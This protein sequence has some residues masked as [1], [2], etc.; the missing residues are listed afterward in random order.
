MKTCTKCGRTLP[1]AVFHRDAS[2]HDG[3]RTWCKTCKNA[4]N[5]LYRQS[6]L[7]RVVCAKYALTHRVARRRASRDYDEARR[8]TKREYDRQYRA[9]HRDARQ[10]Y[11]RGYQ[12][13]HLES[14]A[15]YGAKRRAAK[16][17]AAAER[18]CRAVV[19]RRD[20]GRCHLCGKKVSKKSWHLDHIVPLSQGGEHAYRN[21]AV[22]CPACNLRKNSRRIG[23]LLLIG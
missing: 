18:V 16:S 11:Q 2:S 13:A 15:D 1:L 6:P 7:G 22:A 3:L 4:S 9:A 20:G 19:Y 17:G 21:V 14:W 5:A 10:E 23:Q 8:D 12:A